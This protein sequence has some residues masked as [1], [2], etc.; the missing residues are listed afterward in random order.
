EDERVGVRVTSAPDLPKREPSAIQ[1]N[2]FP[3]HVQ[4]QQS[5]PVVV[6]AA[7]PEVA[8]SHYP[9]AAEIPIGAAVAV[10]V[11]GHGA[12][13]VGGILVLLQYQRTAP[14]ESPA[15]ESRVH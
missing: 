9:R 6:R 3:V 11:D 12:I 10:R 14:C 5:E 13:E 8:I 7:H 2:G 15:G 1:H 4:A